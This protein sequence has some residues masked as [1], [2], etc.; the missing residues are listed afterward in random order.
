MDNTVA[1][2]LSTGERP[3]QCL[4]RESM[5]EASL[6]EHVVKNAQT[7]GTMTYF[8]VRDA[9]AGGEV[10]LCQPECQYVYDLE[11][12]KDVIPQ[13]NDDEAVD[14]QLLSIQEVQEALAD[15]KFKPN[16][17]LLVVEFFV[18]HGIITPENEA[19]YLEIVSRLHRRL[20]FPMGQVAA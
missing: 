4:I 19:N 6:P 15:G 13:P 2:G 3:F 18:R 11:L 17:A 7:C 5:E 14:F 9:R 1:G 10:G 12:P 20:E 8:Y 16:C